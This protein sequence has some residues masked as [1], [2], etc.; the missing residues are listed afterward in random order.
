[1]ATP[2]PLSRGDEKS[3]FSEE[4]IHERNKFD[5]DERLTGPEVLEVYAL[6]LA[7][8]QGKRLSQ[9]LVRAKLT[10]EQLRLWHQLA[11]IPAIMLQD[12][13]MA[14][15][16]NGVKETCMSCLGGG[17]GQDSTP[18]PRC[19]GKGWVRAPADPRIVKL[20]HDAALDVKDRNLGKP[21]ER[22]QIAQ[23]VK[24]VMGGVDPGRLPDAPRRSEAT[25]PE[26]DEETP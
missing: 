12:R 1:M 5:Q 18:C 7:S 22:V 2:Q 14:T 9:R 24:V 11:L 3:I 19:K 6:R 16:L 13:L 10:D 4:W 23:A 20:A 25:P 15:A 21:T 17:K 26:D 8:I